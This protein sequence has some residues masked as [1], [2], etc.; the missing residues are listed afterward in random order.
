MKTLK[1][2]DGVHKEL[3]KFC[4][5]LDSSNVLSSLSDIGGYAIMEYLKRE[6]HKFSAK[7]KSA[8]K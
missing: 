5:N 7:P 2:T 6:G 3:K 1:I 8:K 4:A